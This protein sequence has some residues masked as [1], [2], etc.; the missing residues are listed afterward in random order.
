MVNG[1]IEGRLAAGVT[2]DAM[3]DLWPRILHMSHNWAQRVRAETRDQVRAELT[4]GL[5]QQILGDLLPG[6]TG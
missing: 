3:V 2:A 1:L 5:R 4:S 6:I